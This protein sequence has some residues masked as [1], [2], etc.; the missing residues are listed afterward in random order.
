V[1]LDEQD[2][3][4]WNSALIAAALPHLR[5]AVAGAPQGRRTFQARLQALWCGRPS[6]SHP[7]PWPQVLALYDEMLGISGDAFVRLNRAVA[8][9]ALGR[10]GEA[11]ES[12]QPI[13]TAALE[14]HPMWHA[15]RADLLARAGQPDAARA[16][17][18]AALAQDLPP[19]E[20]SF[21]EAR[22]AALA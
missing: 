6:L 7:A 17:Y 22:R 1:P 13:A 12:L 4:R 18:S 11:L 15:V 16:A 5:A 19:A 20:R 3:A 2:P 9:G 21:L 14:T 10:A 8:L